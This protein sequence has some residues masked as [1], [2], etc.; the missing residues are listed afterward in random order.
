MVRSLLSSVVCAFLAVFHGGLFS[1]SRS[2][3]I[4]VEGSVVDI[5]S[6]R[7]PSVRAAGRRPTLEREPTEHE[8]SNES[9]GEEE[10]EEED[11]DATGYLSTSDS[12][13]D[14][15][16]VNSADST[17]KDTYSRLLRL[18]KYRYK[19]VFRSKATARRY[20]ADP[21]AGIFLDVA[22]AANARKLPVVS[23]RIREP[24]W[25]ASAA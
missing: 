12:E 22:E 5:A 2:L 14:P 20:V 21:C 11:G 23:T 13:D 16:D 15:M 6:E 4:G 19:V 17:Q 18:F 25:A 8:D 9:E 10:D 24:L 3:E 7:A 1:L